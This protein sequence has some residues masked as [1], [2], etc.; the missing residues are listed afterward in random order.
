VTDR[1]QYIVHHRVQAKRNHC[2][3]ACT[4]IALSGLGEDTPQDAISATWWEHPHGFALPDAAKFLAKRTALR[5]VEPPWENAAT[6]DRMR[7]EL[8]HS[9]WIIACT[10]AQEIARVVQA[11]TPAPESPFGPMPAGGRHAVVLVDADDEGFYYLDPYYGAAGQPFSMSNEDFV[12]AFQG[13]A[14]AVRLR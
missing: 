1:S 9:H 5:V 13:A 4:S 7:L 12:Q 11:M 6:F 2:I 10:F 3:V 14:F 8:R